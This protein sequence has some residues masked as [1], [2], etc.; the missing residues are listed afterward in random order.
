MSREEAFWAQVRKTDD[1]WEWVGP[2]DFRFGYGRFTYE[3]TRYPTHRF[4]YELAFGPIGE[5]LCVC[6]RCDNPKCVRPDH[7]FL[8]TRAVNNKDAAQKGRL[9]KGQTHHNAK[10]SDDDVRFIRANYGR[11]GRGGM[12]QVQ[13]ASRFGV[14]QVLVG[15][16]VRGKAWA[17][18]T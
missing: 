2:G 9:P 15:L 8:G 10:L 11:G 17:H 18:L 4:S 14:S 6:H 13:L 1:C 12:S 3:A 16:I 5:G 7:L